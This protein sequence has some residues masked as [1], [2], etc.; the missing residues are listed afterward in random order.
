M[1]QVLKDIENMV[2]LAELR[3][4]KPTSDIEVIDTQTGEVVATYKA[5][6]PGKEIR[7]VDSSVNP[8]E[9]RFVARV[10]VE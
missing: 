9:A 6:L 4:Q 3:G 5:G 8:R 1:S 2:S 10:T 7:E